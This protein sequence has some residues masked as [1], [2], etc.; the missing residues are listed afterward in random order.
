MMRERGARCPRATVSER[1]KGRH[2]RK[3]NCS[4]RRSVWI[5]HCYVQKGEDGSKERSWYGE[6]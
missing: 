6:H 4:L 5:A 1:G 2:I 3:G